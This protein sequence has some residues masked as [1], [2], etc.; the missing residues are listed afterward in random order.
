MGIIK[1]EPIKSFNDILTARMKLVAK[2]DVND[3]QGVKDNIL[4]DLSG[5]GNDGIMTN[6]QIV[7]DSTL[8]K[9]VLSFDNPTTGKSVSYITFA[10]SVVPLRHYLKIHM[11]P[12]V[13]TPITL[14]Q[15]LDTSYNSQ[16]GGIALT[17]PST[18]SGGE[19]GIEYSSYY[20][21]GSGSSPG[22]ILTPAIRNIPANGQSW[23]PIEIVN[24]A[25]VGEKILVKN[26]RGSVTEA[27]FSSTDVFRGHGQRFTLGSPYNTS[28]STRGYKGYLDVVEIYDLDAPVIYLIC[29]SKKK[30]YTIQNGELVT[31]NITLDS[32]DAE[33]KNAIKTKGF[34]DTTQLIDLMKSPSWD[35]TSFSLVL[36]DVVG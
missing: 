14:F 6:V 24:N 33:V 8:G 26:Y 3:P 20:S 15:T 18:T 11:R 7:D 35:M 29:D 9:K 36:Y 5:N 25:M 23:L 22:R 16:Q 13:G 30:L 10:T 31:L 12:T 27:S 34:T 32:T 4:V 19:Y 21:K 17:V 2:Y 1:T 28:E